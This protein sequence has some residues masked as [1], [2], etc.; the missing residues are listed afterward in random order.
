M[1]VIHLGKCALNL[2]G[3]MSL[4]D[5]DLVITFC[6]TALIEY[7]KSSIKD[8]LH[9]VNYFFTFGYVDHDQ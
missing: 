8:Q 1:L 9:K 5:E 2:L 3:N 4:S 6:R 7:A